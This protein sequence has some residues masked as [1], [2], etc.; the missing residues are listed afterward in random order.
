MS[1]EEQPSCI[2]TAKIEVQSNL[3]LYFKTH[4]NLSLSY[5][6]TKMHPPL[7]RPHPDCQ[8]MIDALHQ[9]HAENSKV[10]FWR[11]NKAKGQLDYCLKVEKERMLKELNKD[12]QQ[13]RTKEDGL[14]MEALGQKMSFQEY[15]E[16]DKGYVQAREKKSGSVTSNN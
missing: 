7:D 6:I 5:C 10:F 9:C 12:F 4:T 1:V 15:L 2:V 13:T 8:A 16:K 3:S 14:M 11:C